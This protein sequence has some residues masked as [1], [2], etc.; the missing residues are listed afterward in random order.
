MQDDYNIMMS[1][2]IIMETIN[3][4]FFFLDIILFYLLNVILVYCLPNNH[5]HNYNII[6][7]NYDGINTMV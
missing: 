3:I 4:F 2:T 7:L 6:L 1:M 5:N